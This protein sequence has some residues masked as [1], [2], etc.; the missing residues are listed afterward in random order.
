[1]GVRAVLAADPFDSPNTIRRKGTLNPHLAA[2]GDKTL[3]H[4]GKKLLR[5]FRE[6]YRQAWHELCAGAQCA[7]PAGTYLVARQ[8]G[9]ECAPLQAPW[10]A[11]A[12]S[13]G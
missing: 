2:G 11:A 6:L 8:F 9:V 7:F 1:M 4:E 10:C 12:L 13:P 3:L 5:S